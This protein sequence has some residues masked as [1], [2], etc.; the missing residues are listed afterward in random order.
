MKK[1]LISIIVIS[2]FQSCE[3]GFLDL[4]PVSQANVNDFYKNANDIFNGVNAAYASLQN[5]SLYGGR[6]F[7]DLTEYRAD[8]TFDNDPS[9]NSGLRYNVD[10]FLAGAD[11][12]IFENVWRRLYLT[13]Y[14]CN[15]VLDNI[16][17]INMNAN[18]SIQ[19]LGELQFIRALSYFHLVRLC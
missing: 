12:T 2:L 5:G 8:N 13:I 6:D 19:Y 14:R 9:A 4:S 15:I 17:K 11:N 10:R 18:L 16:P 3:E 7:M 1:I